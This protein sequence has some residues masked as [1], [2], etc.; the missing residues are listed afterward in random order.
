MK[1]NE[2]RKAYKKAWYEANKERIAAEYRARYA[3]DREKYLAKANAYA[4]ANR[5]LLRVKS[6][7]SHA[8]NRKRNNDRQKIYRQRNPDKFAEWAAANRETL[9][10]KKAEWKRKNAAL[11]AAHA[12]AYHAGKLQR[13]VPFSDAKAIAAVYADAARLRESGVDVHVDHIIPLRGKLVSGLHVHWNLQIIPKRDNLRKH[14]KY[15]L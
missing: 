3:T 2:E 10:A 1:T 9:A 15:E 14:N 5:E 7:A 8:K 4:A 12:M 6:S 13:T 11:N